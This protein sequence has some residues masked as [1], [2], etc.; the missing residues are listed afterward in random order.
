MEV[1]VIRH[2]KP[3]VAP[4]ICYGQAEVDLAETFP[5]EAG[6]LQ[7]ELPDH[8]DAVYCSPLY[9]CRAI[10]T[11]LDL[12]NVTFEPALKEMH[13]GE[14]ELQAWDAIDQE[15]LHRW[16]G[17][18]V[19]QHPPGGESLLALY[20]RVTAFL[21]GLK[22]ESASSVLLISHGGVIRCIWSYLLE[23]PLRNVF[24][25]PVAYGEIVKIELTSSPQM[26][27]IIRKQ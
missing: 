16:M 19:T 24:K 6:K 13:F 11:E 17:D 15:Q 26:D 9:R 27:R 5:Q 8:F 3:A 1:Y 4:T 7:E 21:D 22:G 14:W 10:A 12:S 23:I 25:L 18:F 20:Q 2:T